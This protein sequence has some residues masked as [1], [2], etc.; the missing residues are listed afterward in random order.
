[1]RRKDLSEMRQR[2]GEI[3]FIA[4]RGYDPVYDET[5]GEPLW[6]KCHWGSPYTPTRAPF[7]R[8]PATRAGQHDPA[9][10]VGSGLS[11]RGARDP[12]PLPFE[13]GCPE[14]RHRPPATSGSGP[15][16]RRPQHVVKNSWKY[17]DTPLELKPEV[18]LEA[19]ASSAREKREYGMELRAMKE[20]KSARIRKLVKEYSAT[21]LQK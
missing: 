8:S 17:F 15:H 5:L 20:P 12:S 13:S 3:M 9:A 7:R 6:I 14:P 11:Q 19:L 16:P 4:E 21:L 18:D 1:V 10:T 2:L